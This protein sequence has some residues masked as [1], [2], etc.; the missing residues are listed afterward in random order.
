M[1][2]LV[3]KVPTWGSQ[4]GCKGGEEHGTCPRQM[5]PAQ[6]LSQS[7]ISYAGFQNSTSVTLISTP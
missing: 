3:R 1:A 6:D 4:R 5:L 2:T 7:T